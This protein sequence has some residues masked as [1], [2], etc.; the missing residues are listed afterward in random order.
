MKSG[1]NTPLGN[2]SNYKALVCIFPVF[3]GNDGNNLLIPNDS[4]YAANYQT[5]R[6]VLAVPQGNLLPLNPVNPPN[7]GGSYGLHPGMPEIAALFNSGQAAVLANVGTLLAPI[8]Q[9]QYN[10]RERGCSPATVF[11]PGSAD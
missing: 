10:A 11:A 4:R 8:T 5:P 2:G 3:G 7:G 6:G 1:K 9:A